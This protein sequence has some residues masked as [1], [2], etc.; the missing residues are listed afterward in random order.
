MSFEFN[1]KI[2]NLTSKLQGLQQN[3]KKEVDLEDVKGQLRKLN[4]AFQK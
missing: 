4:E 3:S 2:Q 1:S